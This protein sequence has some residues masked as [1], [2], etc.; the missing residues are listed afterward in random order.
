MNHRKDACP[1]TMALQ[2]ALDS[3]SVTHRNQFVETCLEELYPKIYALVFDYFSDVHYAEDVASEIFEKIIITDLKRFPLHDESYLRNY[4]LRIALNHCNDSYRIQKRNKSRFEVVDQIPETGKWDQDRQQR[5]FGFS[6][7]NMLENELSA[8]QRKV[9]CLLMEKHSNQEIAD[10][11]G[12][13]LSAVKNRIY[14]ARMKLKA[15]LR[16]A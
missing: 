11:L 15:I 1:L 5:E 2:K 14:R 12:L 13:S 3:P 10:E 4:I 7:K 8:E 6:A 9:I 16:A